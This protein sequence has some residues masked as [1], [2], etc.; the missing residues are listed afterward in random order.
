MRIA[1][2][3]SILVCETV[4]LADEG[5]TKLRFTRTLPSETQTQIVEKATLAFYIP[6]E[7]GGSVEP[8]FLSQEKVDLSWDADTSSFRCS[9]NLFEDCSEFTFTL[10]LM[11]SAS[12]STPLI[13]QTDENGEPILTLMRATRGSFR[14]SMKSAT[15]QWSVHQLP[16]I[17]PRSNIPFFFALTYEAGKSPK[18]VSLRIALGDKR[19][20]L[21]LNGRF[22]TSGKGQLFLGGRGSRI[23]EFVFFERA[24]SQDE[25]EALSGISFDQEVAVMPTAGNLQM[26]TLT[27]PES[28]INQ[29]RFSSDSQRLA[30]V[31]NDP[32]IWIWQL[33]SLELE[34]SIPVD[35]STREV[36][37]SS[38]DRIIAAS[39]KAPP[40]LFMLESGT[41]VGRNSARAKMPDSLS[42][43]SQCI[44]FA[45][46]GKDVFYS[47]A[48]TFNNF[49]YLSQQTNCSASIPSGMRGIA[50]S[51]NAELIV[52]THNGGQVISWD[53][54]TLKKTRSYE[55]HTGK[56]YDVAFSPDGRL[57]ATSSG[58]L[59]IRVWDVATTKCL[60]VLQGHQEG[61]KSVAFHPREDLIISGSYDR[62]V[63]FWDSQTWEQ[64]YQIENVAANH[65]AVSPDGQW[66]AFGGD[67]LSRSFPNSNAE[68]YSITLL[69]TNELKAHLVRSSTKRK[70]ARQ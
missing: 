7:L 54:E 34:K 65:V 64:V 43:E 67:Y 53:C 23:P 5:Q 27:G 16:I 35:F 20:R 48:R 37:F 31:S 4:C 15:G 14:F 70:S 58:D 25:L 13:N 18:D 8:N 69:E 2:L 17:H 22:E 26:H 55:G 9:E 28:A 41:L 44:E 19:F 24:I 1:V 21:A 56:V 61:V 49:N 51:P 3:V 57:I 66:I 63:R 6:L 30:A 12:S 46:N 52:S 68:S 45:P 39:G 32:A 36:R 10:A 50:I 42:G 11:A 33:P 40:H 47:L 29:L 62:S 38:D 60:A 59:T